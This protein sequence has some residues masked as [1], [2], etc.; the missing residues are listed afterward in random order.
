MCV[1]INHSFPKLERIET[2]N[3]R[4]YKTPEG[5]IY[6]SVTN[7]CGLTSQE[8]IEQWKQNVGEEVAIKIS[9][10]ATKRGTGIH[11]LCEQ[12]IKTGTANP[13]M[14][15]KE[16]FNSMI[17]YLDKIDYVEAMEQSMYSKFL[18]V[19][20][21]VDIIG[22][23]NGVPSIID[24]KTSSRV[25]TKDEIDGY[26][27]QAFCYGQSFFELTDIRINQLVIIMGI[28]DHPVSVFID[29]AQNWRDKALQVRQHFKKV[30]GY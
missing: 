11:S 21:T 8:A 4:Q 30:K 19:A 27:C 5:N 22:T 16:M 24:F 15:D 18:E 14:F 1:F 6:P 9:K 25:K 2:E 17:P 28:D 23:L 13:D 10:T 12:Y 3:G 29:R 26:F 20:G 7:V